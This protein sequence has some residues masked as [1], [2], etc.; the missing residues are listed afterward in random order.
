[1]SA[2]VTQICNLALLKFGN[3]T[4]N[5][6]NDN[7]AQANACKELYPLMRDEL[8]SMHNWNFALARADI[9]G[10][11]QA[12][13]A[14]QFDFSYRLPVK[15]MRVVEL[16]GTDAEWVREG[17]LLLT[18]QEEEIFIRYIQQVTTT[19]NFPQVFVNSLATRLAAELAA[20]ITQ[21]KGGK[22]QKLLTELERVILPEA[23]RINAIEGNR[24]RTKG[25]QSMDNGNYSWQ[26]E[27]R[28][29]TVIDNSGVESI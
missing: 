8:Q 3:I 4:I 5:D 28:G 12:T 29:G 6:I 25:E 23:Y 22:R 7:N 2:S 14:F 18:N 16:Y 17:N 27:G 21:D 20:K 1:M 11:L 19:G 9:T 13:P 26:R 10:A 15:C 24:P